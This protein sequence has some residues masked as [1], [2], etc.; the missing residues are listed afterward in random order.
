MAAHPLVTSTAVILLAAEAAVAAE[1]GWDL[2][3]AHP[4]SA[5]AAV[6]L[7]ATEA[8]VVAKVSRVLRHHFKIIKTARSY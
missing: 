1:G 3:T 4:L 8:A 5:P 2:A 7:F 6:I